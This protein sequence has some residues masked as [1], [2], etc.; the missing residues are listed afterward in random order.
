MEQ[1][2]ILLVGRAPER[3]GL[4]GPQGEKGTKLQELSR[5]PRPLDMGSKNVVFPLEG[6]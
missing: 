1:W 4:G 5:C 2:F 6:L 3:S